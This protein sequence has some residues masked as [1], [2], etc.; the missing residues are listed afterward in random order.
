[1]ALLPSQCYFAHR[2]GSVH[3][4]CLLP[5][6]R[7]IRTVCVLRSSAI[8]TPASG[9]GFDALV[10]KEGRRSRHRLVSLSIKRT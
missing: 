10:V 7:V 2:A 6:S 9:T 1:V 8:A 4:M 5:I 3:A